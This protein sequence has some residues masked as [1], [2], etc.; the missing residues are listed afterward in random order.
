MTEPAYTAITAA[1][2]IEEKSFSTF[3][4]NGVDF[5]ICRLPDGYYAFENRCSHALSYFDNGRLRGHRIMCP[6]HGATFDVRSGACTGAP[7]SRPIR[8]FPLRIV[9]GMI[10]VDLSAKG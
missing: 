3:E 1:E 5:V 2:D 8:T 9:D 6:L 10:E 4:V 7:A